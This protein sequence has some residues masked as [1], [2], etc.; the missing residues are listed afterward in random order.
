MIAGMPDESRGLYEQLITEAIQCR[1]RELAVRYDVKRSSLRVPEAADRISFHVG[2]V[3]R[4]AIGSVSERERV[5]V[6]I[7]LARQIIDT[8]DDCTNA[9]AQ[10]DSPLV[11]GEVLQAVARRQPDGT[12]EQIPGPLIPLLDTTL[13]TNAPGEPR[14]G[15]QLDAE[16]ASSNRIDLVMAFIRRSGIRPLKAALRS[17]CDDDRKLRVL[18]TSY[19]GSTES[20]ALCEL[21]ELGADIRVSYDTRTTRLHAKAWLFHRDSGFSTAYIGS[22]L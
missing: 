12:P 9:G 14:V 3:V 5:A 11:P 16:I 13:L 8:I 10:P 2:Q 18:T 15:K 17:H 1:L 21:K 20:R 7:A 22:S 6:G 19:T 4:R